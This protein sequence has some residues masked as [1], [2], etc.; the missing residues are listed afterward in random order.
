MPKQGRHDPP[1]RRRLHH[2]K[3]GAAHARRRVLAIVGEPEVTVVALETGEI[4]SMHLIEPDT[5]YWRNTRRDPGR[6]PGLERPADHTCR[7]CRDSCVAHV[8]THDNGRGER[9]SAALT[10]R[11]LSFLMVNATPRRPEPLELARSA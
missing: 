5:E 7:R 9:D 2:L 11:S 6:W 10:Q 3:V 1:A 8:A 4:L